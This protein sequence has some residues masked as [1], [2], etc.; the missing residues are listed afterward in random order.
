MSANSS[1]SDVRLD[2]G[3]GESPSR[4]APEPDTPFRIAVFGDFSG[5]ASRDLVRTGRELASLRPIRVDRDNCSEV[6]AKLDVRLQVPE[7]GE[8]LLRDLDSFH[9]DRLYAE[10]PFFE[11]VRT[12]TRQLSS[13]SVGSM[14]KPV[15]R[16]STPPPKLESGS[17]LDRAVAETEREATKAPPKSQDDL[18]AWLDEQVAPHL[19]SKADQRVAE[20]RAVVAE[21][22]GA[23]IRALLHFPSFQQLEALWRA[24]HQLVRGVE[25][26]SML[27]LH[28][29]DI[30]KQELAADLS[31]TPDL[32]ESVIWKALTDSSDEARFGLLLGVYEFGAEEEDLRL[33]VALGTIGAELG[34]PWI[35]DADPSLVG[36]RSFGATPDLDDWASEPDPRWQVLRRHSMAAWIGLAMPRLLLRLPYGKDTDPCEG[37]AFEEIADGPEHSRYL[38]GSAA[39]ACGCLL[40]RSFAVG[41]WDFQPGDHRELEG[42]PLH[43]YTKDGEPC[44]QSPSEAWLS[45][46]AAE[47]ILDRGV[48]PLVS[49]R[50]TD[51]VR[52]VRFQSVAD[53]V[54]PLSGR[55]GRR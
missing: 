10:V 44:V 28:L 48:I 1:R 47:R 3:V 25:T 13:L 19:E 2:V 36:C 46:R 14:P 18:Q 38:W 24:L 49:P 29:V 39:I 45:E 6:M 12:A 35:S 50:M 23:Q 54:A 51:S 32:R 5:R 9:P 26:N 15:R 42:L 4:I 37:M 8:I 40:A 53:P 20:L 17:L 7:A 30:S 33:L 16:P 41:G 11:K 31:D 43:T 27:S 22:A 52:V 34:A 21:T 55:W